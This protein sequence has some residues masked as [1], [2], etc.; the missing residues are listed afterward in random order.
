MSGPISRFSQLKD[1]LS[2]IERFLPDRND[3][4]DAL[5][6][7]T[8]GLAFKV[9]LADNLGIYLKPMINNPLQLCTASCI[10]VVLA[11]SFQIYFDFY[12]YSLIAI[13]PWPP[14]WFSAS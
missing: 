12:G 8:K 6:F 14:V 5:V 9:L 2:H 1:R 4:T 13:G 7:I 11:Y 3:I 10:Y